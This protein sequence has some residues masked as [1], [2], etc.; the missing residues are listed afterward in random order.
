MKNTQKPR[1]SAF[2]RFFSAISALAIILLAGYLIS[3][4]AIVYA[5][6]VLLMGFLIRNFVLMCARQD[7]DFQ[8]MQEQ[9][10]KERNQFFY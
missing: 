6:A 7:E 8:A 3:Y 5:F 10:E 4:G 1:Y 2:Y 9:E